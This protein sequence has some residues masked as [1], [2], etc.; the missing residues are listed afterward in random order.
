VISQEIIFIRN[1]LTEVVDKATKEATERA[2]IIGATA[3]KG[4]YLVT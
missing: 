1:L 4:Q 3:L 2:V